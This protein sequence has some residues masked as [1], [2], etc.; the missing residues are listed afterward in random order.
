[1][2]KHYKVPVLLIEFN[3][4]KVRKFLSVVWEIKQKDIPF[5]SKNR[6]EIMKK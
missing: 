1:M 4:D 5:V 6:L 3:P 2:L